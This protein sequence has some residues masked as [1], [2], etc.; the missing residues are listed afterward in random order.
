MGVG[1]C[2]VVDFIAGLFVAT[3]GV[4]RA[5]ICVGFIF[6][7]TSRV[8]PAGLPGPLHGD[9]FTF[10]GFAHFEPAK[11][12]MKGRGYRRESR[13]AAR[14]SSADYGPAEPYERREAKHDYVQCS[15]KRKRIRTQV[16]WLR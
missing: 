11:E 10:E 5:T 4:R 14:M 6:A 7:R 3:C 1:V 2:R 8:R 16:R 15:A 9:A 13:G 12:A